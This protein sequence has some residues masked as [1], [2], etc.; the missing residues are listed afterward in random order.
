MGKDEKELCEAGFELG[1]YELD[2]SVWAVIYACIHINI[3]IHNAYVYI[4]VYIPPEIGP[5]EH[6]SNDILGQ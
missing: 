4:H 1:K 6:R 2:L 5:H 3:Y